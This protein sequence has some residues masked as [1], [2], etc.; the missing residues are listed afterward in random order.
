MDFSTVCFRSR[1]AQQQM[2]SVGLMGVAHK[3][4]RVRHDGP[5]LQNVRTKFEE[6]AVMVTSGNFVS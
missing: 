3:V 5:G 2:Q 4:S 6:L 1:Q